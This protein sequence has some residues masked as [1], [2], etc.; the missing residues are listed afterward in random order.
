MYNP[1]S[2]IKPFITYLLE[3]MENRLLLL[4]SCNFYFY[5]YLVPIFLGYDL[6]S[7]TNCIYLILKINVK[8]C[9]VLL[10]VARGDPHV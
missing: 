1:S 8:V 9:D 4:G 5:S 7:L 2:I 3:L 6:L 10:E